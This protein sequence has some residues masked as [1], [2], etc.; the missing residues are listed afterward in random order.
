MLEQL[1]NQM[2]TGGWS[3]LDGMGEKF[4][5]MAQEQSAVE[6]QEIERQAAIFAETFGTDAGKRALDI[7]LRMTL[8][9]QPDDLERGATSA[10]AYAI[11]KAKREGQNS[12]VFLLLARLQQHSERK[13]Q[14][15]AKKSEPAPAQKRARPGSRRR[16]H[17]G[18][19]L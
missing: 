7:L 8:L 4:G 10:D 19:D 9:R 1:L 11:A 13:T 15:P 6:N 12:I 3:D 18:G 16:K 17:S 14:E 5:K 2:A